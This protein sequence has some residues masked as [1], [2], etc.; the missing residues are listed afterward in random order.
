MSI[1]RVPASRVLLAALALAVSGACAAQGRDASR[2]GKDLT[3]AGGEAAASKDGSIPAYAGTEAPTAGWAWGKKRLDHWKHKAEA[4]LYTIDASNV[5]KYADKLSPGQLALVKQTKGYKM[6]VYPTHRS[7]G[8]PDFVA[9]NTKKNLATAKLKDN[10]WALQEAVLPGFPFPLP[11]NGAQAMWNAKMRYRGLAVD[12]K[13]VITAASPRK[14]SDEWIKAF[15]EQTN[16]FPWGAKG[17]QLFS[18]LPQVENYV[19]F[20]YNAP[21][22]LAGQA[23]AITIYTELPTET[24]YYFP[25][26][27]RVRRMPTYAYDAPQIGFENQYT[28]DEPYVFNGLMDRFDWKLVGKKDMIVPY[29]AFGAY[30]FSAKFDEVAGKDFLAASHRRYELHRVWVVE[31]TVKAGMRHLA[32]KR[33]FYLDE[34]S[35]NP[36]VADDYDGQ[37]KLWKVREGYSIPVYETGTCDVSAFAQYNLLEGR[38]VFDEHAAGTGADVRWITEP[39]G[40]ARLTPNFYTAE[41]LRSISER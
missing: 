34:D 37:G 31:A 24:Q 38:Y 11:E 5:D 16:Y 4:P 14:G 15:S 12:Y 29:N 35:W 10:G 7:C 27:R 3:P 8:V 20:G 22:A 2:L 18:K 19:Y 28:L 9:E 33:T 17:S 21:A 36:L 26:Q 25:G 1:S 32:P 41:N 40:N 13:N 39:G 6:A 23:L 30:D